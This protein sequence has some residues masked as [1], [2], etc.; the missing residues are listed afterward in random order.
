[1]ERLEEV[2][3]IIGEKPQEKTCDAIMGIVDEGSEIM[4]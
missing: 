4:G 2:F 1:M 3:Q